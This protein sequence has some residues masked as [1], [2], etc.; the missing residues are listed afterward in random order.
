MTTHSEKIIRIAHVVYSFSTIGGL[1]NGLINLLNNLDPGRFFHVVCSL[2]GLGNIVD[3]VKNH[4]VTYHALGKREGNDLRV[5][6]LLW[7][8][9]RQEKI[10]VVHLRNWA[11]MVEGYVAAR[12]ANISKIIYS[13]HGRHFED[14]WQKKSSSL[15]FTVI[16]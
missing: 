10:N 2:T 11:T 1:E 12:A 16:F 13:E 9:F 3:R 7:K 4:N 14:I 5:P 6:F 8:V 15:L